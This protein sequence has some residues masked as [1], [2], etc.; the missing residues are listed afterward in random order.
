MSPAYL[1]FEICV[2]LIP[3]TAISLNFG[4]P[5]EIILLPLV[6]KTKKVKYVIIGGTDIRA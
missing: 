4:L 2:E 6:R 3:L 1:T 5:H